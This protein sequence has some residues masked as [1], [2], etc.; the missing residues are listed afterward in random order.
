MINPL[1]KVSHKWKLTLQVIPVV[2]A[3]IALKYIAHIFNLELF[4]LSPLF[5]AV[6]SATVF[7]I[8]FLIT[9]VISDYKESEKLPGEMACSLETFVDDS[10]VLKANGQNEMAVSM[11][12]YTNDT[13]SMILDWFHKKTRTAEL[14]AR[15]SGY[16]E[17]FQKLEPLTQPNFILRLKQEQSQLR[18][19]ITRIHTIRETSFNPAAYAIVE[20]ISGILCIGLI[21][22]K[23]EPARESMFFVAFVSFFLVYMIFLI[24]DFDNPFGYYADDNVTENISLNPINNLRDRLANMRQTFIG[25]E[26][27]R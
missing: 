12:T 23:V 11:Y 20:I 13:V 24:K 14:L 17:Y 9:G 4:S 18:R 16:S 19:L 25:Q 15:L 8:G 2:A 6:I 27:A 3:L 5:G 7:L 1:N 21:F 26:Q 10:L 22:A